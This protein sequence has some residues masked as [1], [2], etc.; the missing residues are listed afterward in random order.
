MD[1]LTSLLIGIGLS[2]DCFAVSLAIGTT[3]RSQ[4]RKTALV[5]AASF[6]L[7]QA[8]MTVAGWIAVPPSTR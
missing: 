8:V 2:M 4:I 7:F 1:L 3:T 5:I 6:S